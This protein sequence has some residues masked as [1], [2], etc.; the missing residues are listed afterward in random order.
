MF[1][2]KCALKLVPKKYATRLVYF[3]FT[4]YINEIVDCVLG[5][6]SNKCRPNRSA[7]LEDDHFYLN[8]NTQ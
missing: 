4:L 5:E 2:L 6:Y 1:I 3:V 7:V 8:T